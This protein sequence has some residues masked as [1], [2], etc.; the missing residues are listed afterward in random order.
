MTN[1]NKSN[2]TVS[3]EFTQ[4]EFQIL[5]HIV[6]N[7]DFAEL[8]YHFDEDECDQA[9]NIDQKLHHAHVHISNMRG[10]VE[11]KG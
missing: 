8:N 2:E 7:F 10:S 4:T 1:K 5:H 9:F 11:T 3:L 6:C